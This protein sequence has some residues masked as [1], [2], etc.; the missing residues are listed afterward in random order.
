MNLKTKILLWILGSI[1]ILNTIA[2]LWF[3]ISIS[4]EINASWYVWIAVIA[5]LILVITGIFGARYIQ[6]IMRKENERK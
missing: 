2:D 5:T 1:A 6:K 3:R 4:K